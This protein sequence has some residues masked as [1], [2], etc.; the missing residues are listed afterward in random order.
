MSIEAL[1]VAAGRGTRAGGS[2]PKQ[3][4]A[5]RGQAVLT[6]TIHAMLAAP[7][8][9][10]LR[11]VIHPDDLDRYTAAVETV[12]D[13]RVHPPVMGGATRSDSVAAGLAACRADHVLIHDAARPLVPRD[14]I[15]RLLEAMSH[16]RAATL[17][18]PLSDAL[19]H[20]NEGN[21]DRSQ[22]RDG[23]WRAQTPQAFRTG[24]I[25]AA[26]AAATHS[27]ADDVETARAFGI[28]VALVEGSERNIKITRPG[29]FDIAANLLGGPMD[30]RTGNGFD[31][32]AFDTGD[33]VTL[34]GVTIPHDLGLRGHSDADVAMHAITDAIFG[35]LGEGDIGQWFPPSDATW[36]GAASHVFLTKAVERT[37]KRGFVISNIDCTIICEHPRIGPHANA[38]RK[39]LAEIAGIEETRISVKA[40]TSEGL[41][42]T[43]RSEGIASMAT[44]TLVRP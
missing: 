21:A 6:R 10:S 18:V 30:I 34:N 25:R 12:T 27:H 17:A 19:W 22:P 42:F 37:T 43:G 32:H 16:N 41:G 38:M 7:Q 28:D 33:H 40:T 15:D 5:L 3:Y 9:D 36:K 24:D 4:R 11:V 39:R 2:A 20:E 26:H 8:V 13:P 44:A 29:D 35:A 23:L 14:A 1:I 31:V